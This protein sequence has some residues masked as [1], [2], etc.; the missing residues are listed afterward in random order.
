MKEWLDRHFVPYWRQAW[1]LWSLR[2][3]VIASGLITYVLTAPD[4]LL[5]VL[6]SLPPEL[7]EWL[8]AFAGPALLAIVTITRLWNQN[9]DK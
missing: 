3:G 2:L 8:P 1:R 7:R 4:V 5:Q 6:N 9:H